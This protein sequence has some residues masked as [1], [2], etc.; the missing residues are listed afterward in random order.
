MGIWPCIISCMEHVIHTIFEVNVGKSYGIMNRIVLYCIIVSYYMILYDIILYDI[1]WYYMVKWVNMKW[2][3]KWT[4]KSYASNGN[5]SPRRNGGHVIL[6]GRQWRVLSADP[7]ISKKKK[8]LATWTMGPQNQHVEMIK[9]IQ[10]RTPLVSRKKN[11]T[12]G[13]NMSKIYIY[14]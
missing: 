11:T 8:N 14:K 4:M 13:Q 10:V 3:L 12:S 5:S 9:W 7:D 6:V 2:T 1:I